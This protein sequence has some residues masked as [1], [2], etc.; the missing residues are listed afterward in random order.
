[1]RKEVGG[2]PTSHVLQFVDI[3]RCL[4]EPAAQQQSPKVELRMPDP[5][6]PIS[7]WIRT[8]APLAEIGEKLQKVKV[9]ASFEVDYENVYEW[10]KAKPIGY[11]VELN[12]SRLHHDFALPKD[13][14]L[15]FMLIAV[16]NSTTQSQLILWTH[17]IATGVSKALGIAVAIGEVKHLGDDV[18]QYIASKTISAK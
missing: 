7:F 11:D 18:Y 13:E 17:H 9:I 4:Q 1:M 12:I 10:I 14:P 6:C 16:S 3:V 15:R 8:D 2:T 5:R